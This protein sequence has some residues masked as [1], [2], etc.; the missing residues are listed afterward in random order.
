MNV[1]EL[2]G[3]GPSGLSSGGI[4]VDASGVS[5]GSVLLLVIGRQDLDGISVDS[6]PSGWSEVTRFSTSGATS[7]GDACEV[8]RL[9]GLTTG[10][11]GAL[12]FGVAGNGYKSFSLLE[13]SG[14]SGTIESFETDNATSSAYSLADQSADSGDGCLL[15]FAAGTTGDTLSFSTHTGFTK[16]VDR[17]GGRRSGLSIQSADLIGATGTIAGTQS[18]PSVAAALVFE[19]GTPTLAAVVDE[20]GFDIE[21]V[22]DDT[23]VADF[24]VSAGGSGAE[25]SRTIESVIDLGNGRKRLRLA[26]GSR[27]LDSNLEP[28]VLASDSLIPNDA[29]S[30]NSKQTATTIYHRAFVFTFASAPSVGITIT[31]EPTFTGP[32]VS[33]VS[34]DSPPDGFTIHGVALNPPIGSHPFHPQANFYSADTAAT[35]PITM[36]QD[37]C[38]VAMLAYPLIVAH[39]TNTAFSLG[40]TIEEAGRYWR[41]TTAGTTAASKPSFSSSNETQ[42]DGTVVWTRG[43]PQ[44][45]NSRSLGEKAAVLHCSGSTLLSQQSFRPGFTGGSTKR[46]YTTASLQALP[47][48]SNGFTQNPPLAPIYEVGIDDGGNSSEI[49]NEGDYRPY[50]Q[51]MAIDFGADCVAACSDTASDELIHACVQR[52][53]DYIAMREAG[54]TISANGGWSQGRLPFML[55]AAVALGDKSTLLPIIR[56]HPDGDWRGVEGA[57]QYKY[58]DNTLLTT[59]SITGFDYADGLGGTF[60]DPTNA[61]STY[62]D[63]PVNAYFPASVR[64]SWK[65]VPDWGLRV[66]SAPNRSLPLWSRNPAENHYRNFQEHDRLIYLVVRLGLESDFSEVYLDYADRRR[67]VDGSSTLWDSFIIPNRLAYAFDAEVVD[68]STVEL[69]FNR[70]TTGTDS[71][72]LAGMSCTGGIT[73]SNPVQVGP[74]TWRFTTSG[75]VSGQTISYTAAS[76]DATDT[77][78]TALPDVS[79]SIQNND[80]VLAAIETG[81]L[82]FTEGAPAAAITSTLTLT[83]SDDSI[84]SATVTIT[85]GYAQGQDVLE[86]TDQSGISGAWAPATG[87]MTLTG[88]ATVAQ[89]QAA[90][91]TVAFSNTSNDPTAGT[92]TIEFVVSDGTTNS[93]ALTR[94]VDVAAI[95]DEQSIDTN[96]GVTIT[97]GQTGV[98]ITAAMLSTSDADNDPDEVI[99]TLEAGLDHGTLRNNGAIVNVSNTF[100]QLD[101]NAGR[102]TYDHDG[103]DSTSDFFDFLVDDGILQGL[104]S[105]D[106]FNITITPVDDSPPTLASAVTHSTH[107]VIT[108]TD[109]EAVSVVPQYGVSGFTVTAAGSPIEI[110]IA[111]Q[112]GPLEITLVYGFPIFEAQPTELAY[113]D[114]NVQDAA[115]NA[116]ANFTGLQVDNQ[117]RAS[118]SAAASAASLEE[119]QLRAGDDYTGRPLRIDL[120]TQS[121]LTGKFLIIA[122]QKNDLVRFRVRTAILGTQGAHY[123]L[124]EPPATETCQWFPTLYDGLLRIEHSAGSEET[125]WTGWVRVTAFNTPPVLS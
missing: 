66:H 25:T 107:M 20:N 85:A 70:Y 86:F 102:I 104:V 33:G 27:I 11:E 105:S 61:P 83:D 49:A 18:Q 98:V 79:V 37:D 31:G 38:L 58:V 16:N 74:R 28:S 92:R 30:N 108:L 56:S 32:A 95:N 51:H 2:A 57:E 122:A 23:N 26:N 112:T 124:F 81:S 106:T 22:S 89:Y 115:G 9:D 121:D 64:G 48:D 123:A 78:N 29:A 120:D 114:G 17:F 69:S 53:I 117:S 59:A 1:Q 47:G 42:T 80:P 65:H 101:I 63:S 68:A 35:L 87:V 45:D 44:G 72:W 19:Q 14:V 99:Y 97:E 109:T 50:G 119:I 15:I 40:A 43:Y 82:A 71:G 7:G 10:D 118:A 21:L 8:Y 34:Y 46:R 12:T 103:S 88:V 67:Y 5:E 91:R 73:L 125:I 111:Q 76:G 6:L 39:A 41:C 110:I 90:L 84:A 62:S 60:V 55:F 100:T 24:A 52:G 77:G 4:N 116:L 94:D 75:P 93:N 3:G 36:S 96:T 113:T 13:I 54:L